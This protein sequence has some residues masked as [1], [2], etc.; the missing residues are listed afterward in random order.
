[1]KILI[2]GN[3]PHD[4]GGVANYTRPLAVEFARQGHSVFYFYSGAWNKKY[5]WLFRP[6]LRIE[7]RDFPF[8]C[9]ELINSPN[10]T[11]NFNNPLLDIKSPRAERIFEKYIKS[12]KPD[13]VHVHSRVGL[14]ASL[15]EIASR[16]G[17][18]V[19]NT[20]HV[21]GFLCQKRVMVERDGRPCSGPLNLEKCADCPEPLKL[22][23]LRF[24]ARVERTNRNV[25]PSLVK[26]KRKIVRRSNPGRDVA[27][28]S[29]SLPS[30]QQ[31]RLK[32]ELTRRL[33]YMT[34][35]MNRHVSLN[36]CVSKDVKLTLMRYGVR[37]EKLRV[38]PI[39]SAIAETQ[40]A[41]MHPLH[42]PLVVGNIG[43]VRYYKGTHVLVDA[44]SRLSRD[45]YGL[46]IF[47]PYD[48]DYVT[49]MMKGKEQLPIEFLGWYNPQDLPAILEQ[50]DLMVLPSIC[51]DTAPQTIFES[52]SARIP[53]VASDIGG[54]SDFV[55]DGVNGHLFAP[56]NSD[57]L[58]LKLEGLLR[59]P[60]KIRAFSHNIPRLKTIRENARELISLYEKTGGT[61]KETSG[62]E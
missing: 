41:E 58:A 51:K 12:R 16:N 29:P 8:E 39:G 5:N 32:E 43:G 27:S 38:Q 13:V 11:Y 15:L 62:D 61:E 17:I 35:L 6:Y 44:V 14:P 4:V 37:A 3:D 20:V 40:K 7:G 33:D 60:E 54:F 55:Q 31:E 22:R 36:L 24:F 57:E 49:G 52:Y 23:K 26:I 47:G 18:R 50:I 30:P 59:N 28:P 10:W 56:G 21:Y 1:M 2:I 46:K 45:S 25:L 42:D 48:Q 9:A 19:F 53:I 34:S